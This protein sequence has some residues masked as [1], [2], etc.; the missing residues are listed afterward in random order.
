MWCL[1]PHDVLCVS[2][3]ALKNIFMLEFHPT[4]AIASRIPQ[5]LKYANWVSTAVFAPPLVNN[6]V[7]QSPQG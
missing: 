5:A 2:R 6:T 1:W 4:L 3:P 7:H